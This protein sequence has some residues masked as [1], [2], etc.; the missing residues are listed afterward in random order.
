M[1]DSRN[2]ADNRD[3]DPKRNET[4]FCHNFFINEVDKNEFPTHDVT[5]HCRN[6]VS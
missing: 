3:L 4:V 2:L 5:N 1:Y 6:K